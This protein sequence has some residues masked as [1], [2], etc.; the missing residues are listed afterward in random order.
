MKMRRENQEGLAW[1]IFG[2]YLFL[3]AV[4]YWIGLIIN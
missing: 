3:L 1:K 2:V 4:M